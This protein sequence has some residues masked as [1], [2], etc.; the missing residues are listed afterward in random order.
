MSLRVELWLDEQWNGF[1]VSM[2]IK[3]VKET[4]LD[5]P[6]V[7][8]EQ[9]FLVVEPL[10]YIKRVARKKFQ[11]ISHGR[12]VYERGSATNTVAERRTKIRNDTLK[13]AQVE[14]SLKES[15]LT[16]AEKRRKPMDNA[17]GVKGKEVDARTSSDTR[18]EKEIK[19]FV[20]HPSIS[21]P[22]ISSYTNTNIV[23]DLK[24]KLT[25]EQ[26]KIFGTTCF[27][28][29]LN[30]KHC[31]V[32]HQLFRCFMV[33]QLEGSHDDLFS[34][35]VNGTTLSFLIR[36]FALVT[37]LNCVDDP[38]DFQFNTKVPN[39]IVDTYFSG[40]KN[41]KKKDLLKCFDDN[42]WGHDN[43]GDAIKIA[44]LYFIHTF[45]FSSEK[46][47][48]T[49]PRL[50]FN[51]VESERYSDYPWGK[52]AFQYHIKSISKKMDSQKKYY[53]IAGMPLAMQVWFYE[54][55]SKVDLK[56]ALRVDIR[57]PRIL[58][59]KS[60]INQPTYAYLMNDMF[61]DQGNMIVYNDIQP[62]DIELAVIQIPPEGVDVM[63]EFTS[64]RTLINE[65]F[66]KLSDQVKANQ[67]T[68][69]VYQRKKYTRRHDDGIQMPSD[70]NLQDNPKCQTQS[71]IAVGENSEAMQRKLNT[72][73]HTDQHPHAISTED[74]LN[75]STEVNPIC[76][77]VRM[78]GK[79]TSEVPCTIPHISDEGVSRE[80]HVLQFELADK[81]LPSQIPETRIVIHH[82]TKNV[83]STPL[84]SHRNRHPS[85]WYSSP[86]ES[87]FDSAGTSVKLT[88][89]FDK[90]YPF[91]DDLISRPHP[92]LVIQEYEK[93]VRDGLLAK[94]DQKQMYSI[95][96][97]IQLNIVFTVPGTH[98]DVIFYYLRKKGKYNQTTNFKYTTVDCIFKRRI[99]EIFD[100]YADTDS[101]ASVA[102][103]ED[104]VCEYIRG[105]RLLANVPWYTV[106]IVLISVNLKDKLHWILTVVSF[107]ERCIKVYDSHR[108]AGHDMGSE[109]DKLAKLVPLYLSMSDFYRDKK[110]IDWSHDSAYSDKAQ[111][112]PFDIVF[113]SNL[114]QQKSGSMYVFNP[115]DCIIYKSNNM[116]YF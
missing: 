49:I 68:E 3:K 6:K 38:E 63:G 82:A 113:I 36:E 112:D 26:Y 76:G 1:V 87:N 95:L 10:E 46:N 22:H 70:A 42:N 116:N 47:I 15:T 88:P 24:E 107:K 84:P 17:S 115:L 7:S 29:F 44:V 97:E 40:T 80:V 99:A 100:R 43:D 83:D 31:E 54:C 21:S 51:L 8:S 11:S 55:C 85:R 64:L 4:I 92:T 66:K 27:G 110:V 2:S 19:L 14:K 52:D 98:I 74:T 79:T 61:N 73:I 57:I 93:W 37:G 111:T 33:L 65:N 81:F 12:I 71:D 16:D 45:I 56:I 35:Y 9:A 67:N 53:S 102:K 77:E 58:N 59:W 75:A 25:P 34:I 32:Q 48:T 41:V 104:V 60:T 20:K 13:E 96:T 30:M 5:S 28:S 72:D 90:K 18:D 109:I 94:H 91:E 114:P 69:R 39:R 105:Y 50:H 108:S 106:D 101:N 89:I 62:S 86:Y 78:E 103:E 23:S